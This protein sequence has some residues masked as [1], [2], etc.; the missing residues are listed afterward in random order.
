MKTN[1]VLQKLRGGKAAIG[2]FL[3]LGSP[4]IAELMAHAGMDFLVIETEHNALD[5]AEVEHMIRAVN[6]T[7]TVPIVQRIEI[8]P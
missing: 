6:T 4:T 3:G 2:S 1:H 5:S 7:D 8:V